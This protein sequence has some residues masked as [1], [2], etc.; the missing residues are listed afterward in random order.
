MNKAESATAPESTAAA[1]DRLKALEA[2]AAPLQARLAQVDERLAS[3]DTPAEDRTIE[4]EIAA[5]KEKA[6][7]SVEKGVIAERLVPL[8]GQIATLRAEVK[9][10][11]LREANAVFEAEVLASVERAKAIASQLLAEAEAI[12]KSLENGQKRH[13]RVSMSL[14]RTIGD[15]TKLMVKATSKI[16]VRS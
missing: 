13:L 7:L 3:F 15:L 2:Q 16:S 4:A 10:D 12:Q 8:D 1:A 9:A 11:A 14:R 6:E 5:R